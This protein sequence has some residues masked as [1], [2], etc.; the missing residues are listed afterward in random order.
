MVAVCVFA[1]AA[2]GADFRVDSD[3]VLI[4]VSVT[5]SR[6]HA[7]TGLGREAFHIFDDKTEQTVVH[8]AREDAPLSVGIVFDVSGSMRDKL[9]E[10]GQAVDEFLRG[11][12]P[13]DEFFLVEFGNRP[14]LT[15]PF[16][17]ETGEIRDRLRRAEPHGK[18]ALL[19]AVYLAMDA[20]KSARNA[21]RALLILS[22]GGDNYSRYTRTEMRNRVR[23]SDLWIYAMGIY[24]LHAAILPEETGS[25]PDLLQALAE[26]SG[27][28]HYA[29]EYLADLPRIAG[30]IGLELREQ[31]ILGYRP[32][33]S[34]RDGKYHRVQVKVVE[35]RHLM[36]S[37]RPGYYGTA[38]RSTSTEAAR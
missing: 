21:R 38:V 37:W 20:M 14:R 10:S 1:C 36:V 5:D 28:R 7:I 22:D 35:G 11:A 30:R 32:S 3:L 8:F 15:V 24:D 19:D 31:Y 25:G 26:E 13:Q 12:N 16:T 9:E 23:E 6:S 17:T 18:T 34:R 27:G 29:V 2:P 33:G 4:P